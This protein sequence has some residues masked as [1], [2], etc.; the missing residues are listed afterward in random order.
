MTAI[1]NQKSGVTKTTSTANLGRGL[2]M[3]GG[4]F[5]FTFFYCAFLDFDAKINYNSSMKIKTGDGNRC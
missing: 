1:C 2:A 4:V 3:Q 5:H